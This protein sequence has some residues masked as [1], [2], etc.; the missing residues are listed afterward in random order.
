VS[1]AIILGSSFSKQVPKN[2][3][4]NPVRISTIWGSVT[5]YQVLVPHREDAPSWIIFRHGLPHQ[6]LPH[7]INFRGYIAA[8]KEVGCR[9]LIICSSVGV[10]D[11][12][13]PLYQ[14]M[15]AADLL[16]PDQRLPNGEVCSMFTIP[17]AQQG[18]L[19]LQGR[20]FSNALQQ[21]IIKLTQKLNVQWGPDVNFAYVPGPRTKTALENKYWL[22]LGAQVNS[23]SIG[24]EVVL[25]QEMQIPTVALLVGHKYSKCTLDP[26]SSH[27]QILTLDE[28]N[29]AMEAM[30]AS[31]VNV[32]QVTEAI[33]EIIL[34]KVQTV[35]FDHYLYQF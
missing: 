29:N 24:P 6:V 15:F 10:L 16:M 20:I 35:D 31:L 27:K 22:Q 28:K 25:A 30:Q 14:P 12:Q 7:Q 1:V 18:H 19:V 3:Q 8:L 11:S 13:V 5:L 21:Q 9:S 34:Q 17:Q 26:P 2:I 32:R 4:L 33:I 23:M